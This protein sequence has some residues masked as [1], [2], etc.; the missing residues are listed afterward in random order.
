MGY[1]IYI[2]HRDNLRTSFSQILGG[3]NMNY[4][5]KLQL[6]F[7]PNRNYTVVSILE[8]HCLNS[9]L[10]KMPQP[11]TIDMVNGENTEQGI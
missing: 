6:L 11:S 8:L 2:G 10:T 5:N 4:K 9:Y 7:V 3:N 1:I